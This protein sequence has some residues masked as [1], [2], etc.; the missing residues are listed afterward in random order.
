[1][2]AAKSST[3]LVIGAGGDSSVCVHK[4]AVNPD[5]LPSTSPPTGVGE[6]ATPVIG[7]VVASALSALTG[8]HYT[9]LPIRS[10]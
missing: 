10:A 9:H 2:S 5:I 4:M 6:S 3:V 7:P 8:K 1:M